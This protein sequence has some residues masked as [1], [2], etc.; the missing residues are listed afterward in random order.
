MRLT[1]G[2]AGPFTLWHMSEDPNGQ[3][4]SGR[5]QSLDRAVTLL[6][7]ISAAAPN[8][9]GAAEL[10]VECGLNRATA[11]RLLAALDEHDLV[12][13]DPDTKRYTIGFAV[14][15]MA[16]AAGL[17]G[18]IR[19]SRPVLERLCEQ[20]GETANL[21]VSQRLG[22]TYV[23]EVVPPVVLSA[24]WLGRQI[25]IHA[26]STG[27]AFLAW[28]PESEAEAL[29]AAPLAEYTPST[30]TD[31]G[32]LLE[33][34]TGIR[35]HGYAASA[36]ELEPHVYGVSAAVLDAR[37]RPYAVVSIWGPQERVPTE[38][39]ADLG[40]LAADAAREVAQH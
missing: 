15:R 18:L 5:V 29:L 17:S 31:R 10:A 35:E 7:T 3:A 14:T 23:D 4:G 16:G 39:F 11:W 21:A 36:G 30:V 19:R 34:L 38:R 13:R 6:N 24:R 2:Q 28:L 25:P 22:L 40:G 26:T 33:E 8:G 27:K 1:A 32:A 20:T 37:R 9:L 12:D